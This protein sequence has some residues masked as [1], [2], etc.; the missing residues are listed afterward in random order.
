M[1]INKIKLYNGGRNG[2]D[3]KL[4]ENIQMK[5]FENNK[6]IK[7]RVNR[8]RGVPIPP[9]LREKIYSLRYFF[10]NLT[11]H[12]APPFNKYIEPSLLKLK[13]HDPAE[14]L[15]SGEEFLRALWYGTEIEELEKKDDMFRIKAKLHTL[16]DKYLTITTPWL[17]VEDDCNFYEELSELVKDIMADVV[18]Y[19]T[20][21]T[22]SLEEATVLLKELMSKETD[23]ERVAHQT[24]AENMEEL[25]R[26][27]EE[28]GHI[29]LSP[30]P[31][32]KSIGNGADDVEVRN[33]KQTINPTMYEPNGDAPDATEDN[34][35]TF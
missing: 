16:S 28:S 15:T 22:F 10:F 11:G 23:K 20:S 25:I 31:G 32:S 21:D 4:I 12:W 2:L 24:N 34:G 6:F 35:E 27:L 19:L 13:D 17:D 18:H 29:V 8:Q 26:V 30:E 7:D 5:V 14:E 3:V 9:A 33:S 1:E